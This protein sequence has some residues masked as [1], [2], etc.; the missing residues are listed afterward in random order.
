[1]NPPSID[2]MRFEYG[3]SFIVAGEFQSFIV[4]IGLI[5]AKSTDLDE[6]PHL[7]GIISSRFVS[8]YHLSDLIILVNK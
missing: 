2:T 6:M 4:K 7:A 8:F 5:L 3:V 1:M